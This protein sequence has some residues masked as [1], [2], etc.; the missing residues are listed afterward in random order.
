MDYRQFFKK[1]GGSAR[2]KNVRS[3]TWWPIRAGARNRD[4][5]VYHIPE[6][7]GLPKEFIRL[8]PWEMEFLFATARRAKHGILE[9]GRFN[10]GST[11]LLTCANAS[12]PIWSIDIDPQ[13]DALFKELSRSHGVGQNVHLIIGDS[14]R[15]QYPEIGRYDLLFIDGDH[16]YDGCSADIRSWFG[17]L[18]PGGYI[19]FHDSYTAR[20]NDGVQDAILDFIEARDDVEVV[21][22]PLIGVSYWRYPAGSMACL[23][24]RKAV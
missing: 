8:C 12:V 7:T 14:Q 3:P 2:T 11:F 17:A 1:F 21:I 16:S 4:K 23:R 13:N 19:V 15:T 10:G 6:K 24:K 9:I 22:S 18:H 20:G 5:P